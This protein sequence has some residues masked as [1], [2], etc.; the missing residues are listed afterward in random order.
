[1]SVWFV[2]LLLLAGGAIVWFALEKRQRRTHPVTGGIKLDITVPHTEEFELYGNAFSHCSRKT[3]LV[4]AEL[5]I[6]YRHRHVDLIETGAYGT[7]DPH[8]LRL[9]PAGFIP[10][11]VHNGH[12]VYESDDIL[13][14][15]VEVA[16][17]GA[18]QLIPA[19]GAARAAMRCWIQYCSLSSTNPTWGREQRLGACIPGL[20]LPLFAT[21]IRYVPLHRIATG[22]LF[23]YDRNRPIFFAMA[24]LLGARR[25]LS[26]PRVAALIDG[27]R[28]PMRV[29]LQKVEAA[30]MDSDGPWLLG[31]VFT[32]AD[33]TLACALLRL[34][35][36]GWLERFAK[37]D[38]LQAILDYYRRVRARPSWAA[39]IKRVHHPLVDR[40][41]ADL[42]TSN[43]LDDCFGR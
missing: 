43:L 39:A 1:M 7:L 13:A 27:S 35:E 10:V 23:H 12:P 25:A 42:L 19:D 33:I 4:L 24:K 6:S 36:T 34:E 18:P 30:L 22:L 16:G 20:T 15:A 8:F 11:L 32:L 29:H 40:G 9:N 37:V 17:P 38:G 3:R 21:M 31:P 28:V 14:Y 5:G 2:A 41:V 26:S